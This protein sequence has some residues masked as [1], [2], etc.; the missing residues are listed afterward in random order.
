MK[1][2]LK[3][4]SCGSLRYRNTRLTLSFDYL[5]PSNC[6]VVSNCIAGLFNLTA[7]TNFTHDESMSAKLQQ[8]F[9]DKKKRLRTLLVTNPLIYQTTSQV[10]FIGRFIFAV[11]ERRLRGRTQ[12]MQLL[13]AKFHFYQFWKSQVQRKIDLVLQV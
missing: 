7:K 10:R 13:R 8:N 1:A 4:P 11:I 3:R 12:K 9:C 6:L 5:L 2:C